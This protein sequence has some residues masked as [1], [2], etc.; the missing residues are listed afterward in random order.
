M[1]LFKLKVGSH[2]SGDGPDTK[3]YSAQDPLNN[4][5]DD[6]KVDLATEYPEKFEKYEGAMPQMAVGDRTKVYGEVSPPPPPSDADRRAAETLW[7]PMTVT[8]M[9]ARAKQLREWA[10]TMEQRAQEAQRGQGEQQQQPRQPGQAD[11]T[12]FPGRGPVTAGV[13]PGQTTPPVQQEQ[14]RQQAEQHKQ[15]AGA[16][17]EAAQ[18]ETRE[19]QPEQQERQPEA[20]R[21]TPVQEAQQEP[22][23]REWFASLPPERQQDEDQRLERMSLQQLR[24]L[25]QEEKVEVPGNASKVQ[26]LQAIRQGRK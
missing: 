22:S 12:F 24:V 2:T 18:R 20:Q 25:A 1:A 16:L 7:T 14:Q 11:S 6:P 13:G 23:A 10:D 26:L 5:V 15:A 8:D 9:Q 4:V 21:P 3:F 19:S 17:Q